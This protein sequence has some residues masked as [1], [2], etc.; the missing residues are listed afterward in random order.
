MTMSKTI[1]VLL[2]SGALLL[3]LFTA[4]LFVEGWLWSAMDYVF[5]WAMFSLAG[6]GFTFMA[7]R[8][9]GMEYRFAVGLAVLASF[10][11]VWITAAVGIIGDSD[12]NVL[13]GLVLMT[14]F[15]GTIAARLRPSGMSQALYA[16]ALVQ[17]LVPVIALFNWNPEPQDWSPGVIQVF[18]LN[19]LWVATYAASG[20]LFNHAARNRKEVSA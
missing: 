6:L 11:L 15:L 8:A 16:T 5:A 7:S 1:G 13:Y 20:M 10:L 18:I 2:A 9:N 4:S 14:L 19:M 3:V 12:V 17:F